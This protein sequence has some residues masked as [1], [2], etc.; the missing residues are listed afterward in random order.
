MPDYSKSIIYTIRSRDN[1]YVGST[2]DFRARKYLHKSNLYNENSPKYNYK[3][4]KIIRANECEW[5]MQPYSKYPCKDKLEL[6]IEEERVRQHL[7]ADLN[8][9]CCG[10]GCSTR[11]QYDK[12]Y[13][14]EHKDEIKQWYE[15]NKDKINEKKKQWFEEHKDELKEKALQK[16]KCECN[17]VVT[18]S[19]LA[20]HR[21]S[22]KHINIM[23]KLNQ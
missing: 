10:S 6:T 16:I 20:R 15:Q 5:D 19:C 17:C 12:Q 8:Y 3:L 9:R 14:E 23:E 11:K 13:Y 1:V 7:K 2:I 22:K 21:R 18:Y 4:Y